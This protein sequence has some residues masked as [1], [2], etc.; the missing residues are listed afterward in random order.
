VADGALA[1]IGQIANWIGSWI[2]TWRVLDT[3][4]GAVKFEA[5]F[6]GPRFRRY[7]D[8]L[9]I[10][11]CGPGR[12]WYWP[13][14][15]AFQVYPT[16]IQTDDLPTQTMESADGTPFIAGGMVTYCVPDLE[17][18]LTATHN[19]M[20]MIQVLTLASIHDVCCKMTWAEL[21]L[22]QRK[23]TLDTKLKNHAQKFLTKYGVQVEACMLTDLARSRVYRLIN[24]TQ[25]D[26][27]RPA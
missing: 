2:P 24:S 8:P 3:T 11:T 15:S 7:K 17:K 9:R 22:E 23:G 10:T 26:T 25:Q 21:V 5:F 4:E 14:F 18:L 20:K 6:W 27:S 12:H 19:A 1:W 13:A 16:A